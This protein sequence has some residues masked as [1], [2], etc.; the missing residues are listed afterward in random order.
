MKKLIFLLLI[1]SMNAN[2]ATA[3]F[4]GRSMQVQTVTYQTGWKCQY[5]YGGNTFWRVFIGYCPNSI[6]VYQ[7]MKNPKSLARDGAFKQHCFREKGLLMS[8][9]DQRYAY[10][11]TYPSNIQCSF[12][13][14]PEYHRESLAAR[15]GVIPRF[16]ATVC[17][18]ITAN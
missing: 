1:I 8:K 15:R 17:G 18:P 16:L 9:S 12:L 3:F 7:E 4:T 6:E 13:N 11:R 14:S 10:Y 2:A 5:S